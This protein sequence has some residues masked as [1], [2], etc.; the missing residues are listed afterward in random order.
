MKARYGQG[1]PIANYSDKVRKVKSVLEVQ[2]KLTEFE[3]YKKTMLITDTNF[4]RT[5]LNRRFR[6]FRSQSDP[7][8]KERLLASGVENHPV[9][10]DKVICLKNSKAGSRQIFNGMLGQVLQTSLANGTDMNGNFDF[11][12]RIDGETLA[13]DGKSS[14]HFFNNPKNEAPA[15][16]YYK[17]IGDRWDFGYALTAHKAQGSEEK[18]VFIFGDGKVFTYTDKNNPDIAKQ[19]LYTAITRASEELYICQDKITK[20]TVGGK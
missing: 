15:D 19:W 12:V 11:K 14:V 2:D 18:R 8:Y 4:K 7:E 13:Y 10:G 17:S 6:V 9:V 1:I 3:C 5:F 20:A 16:V